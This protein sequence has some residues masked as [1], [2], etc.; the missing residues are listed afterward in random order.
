MAHLPLEVKSLGRIR[1]KNKSRRQ[2]ILPCV[3]SV[4]VCVC[5][6]VCVNAGVLSHRRDYQSPSLA[7]S[8]QCHRLPPTL[9]P[10]PGSEW[11]LIGCG[12]S[13]LPLAL[14]LPP[15]CLDKCFHINHRSTTTKPWLDVFVGAPHWPYSSR[16]LSEMSAWVDPKGFRTNLRLLLKSSSQ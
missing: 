8:W 16:V 11:P 4:C 15:L 9:A 13:S 7:T 10:P 14:P 6:C 1:T 3:P 2:F 12:S 5:V